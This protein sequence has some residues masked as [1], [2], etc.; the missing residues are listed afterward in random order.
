[1]GIHLLNKTPLYNTSINLLSIDRLHSS[2]HKK[3][4]KE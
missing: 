4:K 3:N 2:R 1:M